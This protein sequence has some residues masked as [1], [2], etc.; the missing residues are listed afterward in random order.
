MKN[1][2]LELVIKSRD[3][4]YSTY[5]KNLLKK[6]KELRVKEYNVIT[7]ESRRLESSSKSNFWLVSYEIEVTYFA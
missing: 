4:L 1:I 6:L 3:G 7:M 2:K 5:K